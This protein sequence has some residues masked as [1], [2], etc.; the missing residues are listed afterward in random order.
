M[1]LKPLADRLFVEPFEHEELTPSGIILPETAREKP[2]QGKV[3]AIGPGAA[4]ENGIR[5]AMDVS[6]E[7]TT[8]AKAD[9]VK[10]VSHFMVRMEVCDGK[11]SNKEYA[12]AKWRG[13]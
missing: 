11:K 13:N 4:Q 5:I 6:K 1:N 7:G 2:M 8:V 10:V 3:W 9:K 12:Y